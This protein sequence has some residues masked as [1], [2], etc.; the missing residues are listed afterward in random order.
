MKIIGRSWGHKWA[1]LREILEARVGI[2]PSSPLQTRKLFI[3]RS[4]KNY[5]NGGN[6]EVRYTA[7]TWG[8]SLARRSH[9]RA[10]II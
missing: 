1:G 5:K 8:T 4:D 2:E 3:P 6:V 9:V 7:G 10:E